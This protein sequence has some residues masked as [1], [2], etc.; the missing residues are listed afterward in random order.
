MALCFNFY[1]PFSG[2]HKLC[3]CVGHWLKIPWWRHPDFMNSRNQ[4]PPVLVFDDP[5]FQR[6]AVPHRLGLAKH[7]GKQ[8]GTGAVRRKVPRLV[9]S[10]SRS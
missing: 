5:L 7:F 3:A 9:G 2:P 1:C 6:R 8:I 4:S 10:L